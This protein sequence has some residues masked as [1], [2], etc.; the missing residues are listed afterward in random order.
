MSHTG[1]LGVLFFKL[2]DSCLFHQERSTREQEWEQMVSHIRLNCKTSSLQWGEVG[3]IS[4]KLGH[5][6]TSNR[7]KENYWPK[8][9]EM[10]HVDI[11]NENTLVSGESGPS[12]HAL[13]RKG[14]SRPRNLGLVSKSFTSLQDWRL[15]S[16]NYW[17]FPL[18][19]SCVA[20]QAVAVK[21][22]KLKEEGLVINESEGKQN[23]LLIKRGPKYW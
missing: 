10:G 16:H 6:L 12:V 23:M 1:W 9:D 14:I 19:L 15:A 4:P 21:N 22:W 17:S 18:R 3:F 8:S 20:I 7:I 11:I 2:I 5:T 13:L